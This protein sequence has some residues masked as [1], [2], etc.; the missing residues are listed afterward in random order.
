MECIDNAFLILK[1]KTYTIVTKVRLREIFSLSP[2]AKFPLV[3]L[4]MLF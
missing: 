1:I 2:Y 4:E 3:N